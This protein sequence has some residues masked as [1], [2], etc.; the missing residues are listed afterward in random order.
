MGGD[1]LTFGLQLRQKLESPEASWWP[2]VDLSNASTKPSPVF[3]DLIGQPGG[4]ESHVFKRWIL[5]LIVWAMNGIKIVLYVDL[6]L[7]IVSLL[8]PG[9]H[10]YI[11]WVKRIE[12]IAHILSMSVIVFHVW[13]QVTTTWCR[14]ENFQCLPTG[15]LAKQG[16]VCCTKYDMREKQLI[17]R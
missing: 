17:F 11:L 10:Y 15:D 14:D 8:F 16:V 4:K 2:V 1:G 7:S 13:F 9:R 5:N 12:G 6:W 3:V